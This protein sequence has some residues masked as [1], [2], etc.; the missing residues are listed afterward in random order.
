MHPVVIALLAGFVL[1]VLYA[2]RMERLVG[3]KQVDAA[4]LKR[5]V[6][7][8][9]VGRDDAGSPWD[10]LGSKTTARGLD[11]LFE[12]DDDPQARAVLRVPGGPEKK[13]ATL[14]TNTV[15]VRLTA[16]FETHHVHSAGYVFRVR[17]RGTGPVV[18]REVQIQMPV[19]GRNRPFGGRIE[20]DDD[21][22]PAVGGWIE[23]ESMEILEVR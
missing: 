11:L 10:D 9:S 5:G 6:T 15:V 17:L 2:V 1:F 12:H 21:H 18:G 4:A 7:L 23:I 22:D 3:P 16:D 8:R 20:N 13:P 14:V 19:A